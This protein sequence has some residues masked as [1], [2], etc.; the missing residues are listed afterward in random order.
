MKTIALSDPAVVTAATRGA[1][2]IGVRGEPWSVF[3][4]SALQRFSSARV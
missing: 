2:E 1:V 3:E 4:H